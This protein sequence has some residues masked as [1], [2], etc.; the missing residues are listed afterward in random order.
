MKHLIFLLPFLFIGVKT[1]AQETM[2]LVGYLNKVRAENLD[3]KIESSKSDAAGANSVGLAIPPPM[4]GVNLMNMDSGNTQGFE[5]NQTLPFPTKLTSDHAARK[6]AAKSQNE[7]RLAR[8]SEVLAEA[9]LLYFTLWA[10]QQRLRLLSEK[11]TVIKNH[12]GLARSSARSDSFA[13][14]HVLRTESDLDLLENE[15]L[16]AEQKEK[17]KQTEAGVF[18]NMDPATFEISTEEPPL[19]KIPKMDSIDDS[20]QVQ[21]MKFNFESLRSKEWL[22]KSSWFPD[23]NLRYRVMGASTML[24]GYNE[25][26]IGVT[27]PFVFFWEPHSESRTATAAR[28]QAEYELEKQRRSVRADK[29]ILLSKV[30]SLKKQIDNLRKKIIPWAQKRMRRVHNLAPRDMEILQDH[31]ETMEAIPDLKLKLLDLRLE[32]ERS[33]SSLEKYVPGNEGFYE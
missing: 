31:R 11:R 33:V 32:Y 26:M 27:L 14:I 1:Q 12:L 2:S 18:I 19:S 7:A 16:E 10:S 22:A 6:Y 29:T 9:K 25:V 28:M 8:G 3:L 30:Q 4:I 24:P 21:M 5:V 20:H 13:S 15:I 17:E 23:I